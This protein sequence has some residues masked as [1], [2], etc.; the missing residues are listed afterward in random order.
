MT[1]LPGPDD[2]PDNLHVVPSADWPGGELIAA[3]DAVVAKAG[4]GTV[5]EAM[6]SGTPIVYPPRRGFSEYRALDRAL[7]AWGGGVPISSRDFH[8]LKLERALAR[9]LELKPGPPPFSTDGATRI[10]SHLVDGMPS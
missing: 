3:S 2:G 8:E 9:A 4:Y 10:A 7:R 5:C 6:A 1:Y